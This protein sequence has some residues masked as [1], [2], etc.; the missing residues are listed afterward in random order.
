LGAIARAIMSVEPPGG[1]GTT[2]DGFGGPCL[3][4]GAGR[5]GQA[6]QK[7]GK[8]LVHDGFSSVDSDCTGAAIRWGAVAGCKVLDRSFG[9]SRF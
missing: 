4:L 9:W 8:Q 5:G 1:N 2:S 3:G 7:G 6:E